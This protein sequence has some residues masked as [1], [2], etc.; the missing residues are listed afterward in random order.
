MKVK[1]DEKLICIPPYISTTWEQVIFL[2]SEE[3]DQTHLFTLILHLTDGKEVRI[4]SL[5]S[6]LV[7]IAFA[8]HIK[9]LE[10]K[11]APASAARNPDNSKALG[12]I[13]QQLTGLSSDQIANMPIKFG[14]AGMEGLPGMEVLQHTQNQSDS[15]EMPA[16]VVEKISGM[17]KMMTNGD[18]ASFPKPEP[19]CNCPHCQVARSIHGISKMETPQEPEVAISEEDLRFRDWDITQ[20]ADQ[21]YCVT[22]PLDPQEQ[23]NVFLGTPVG[24][25][26]GTAHCEHIKAVLYS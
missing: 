10:R 24:C 12:N 7:D 17:I 16:E 26:C 1:I 22:N 9:S 6:S 21:L 18:V 20:K 5:D 14:I 15:P 25:T 23:Y 8:A 4:P 11:G 13:L 2:Q 3:D 19:H